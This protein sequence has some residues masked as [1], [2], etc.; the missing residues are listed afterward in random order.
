MEGKRGPS[1][2]KEML[3]EA[4]AAMRRLSAARLRGW[5]AAQFDGTA[6]IP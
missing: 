3:A 4:N 5:R 2:V 6:L 1:S